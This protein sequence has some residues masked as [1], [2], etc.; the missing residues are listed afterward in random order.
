MLA[1]MNSYGRTSVVERTFTMDDQLRFAS[2]SGDRN[3]LH[4]DTLAARRSVFGRPIVHGIHLVLWALEN[5]LQ[6]QTRISRLQVVFRAP[7]IVGEL[8]RIESFQHQNSLRVV[9]FRREREVAVI[10]V[11]MSGYSE[12][13]S[14]PASSPVPSKVAELTASQI[15]AAKGKLYPT[16]SR[17]DFD[18]M[19]PGLGAR[20]PADQ[21]GVMLASTLLVGNVCPGLYSI[22]SE[23]RCDFSVAHEDV[24][25]FEW[26]VRKFDPRFSRVTV[27]IAGPGFHGELV[28]FLRPPPRSQPSFSEVSARVGRRDYNKRTALVVGG[29]RGLGE[30]CAKLL[31]A[32]GS[33]VWLTYRVGRGDAERVVADIEAGGGRA[34]ALEF[35]VLSENGVSGALSG[36]KPTHVYYFPTVPIFVAEQDRFDAALF[37]KFCSVYVD[38]FVGLLQDL[39]RMGDG[40]LSVFYPSSIAVDAPVRG[41][42][43]YAAAKSAGESVCRYLSKANSELSIHVERLPR[44]ATDQTASLVLHDTADPIAIFQSVLAKC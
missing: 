34:R 3:P 10:D 39:R 6:Q 33:E 42:A 5:C 18:A 40:A 35:D 13:V 8:T 17:S 1:A 38:A 11:D 16:Y 31:A 30:V 44:L 20:L 22:Y 32:G 19:F 12:G 37:R 24:L 29:S 2:L 36:R 41:M 21:I 9:I 4:I 28:A 27:D 15:S 26:S 7:V 25:S 14:V 43:E 23:L